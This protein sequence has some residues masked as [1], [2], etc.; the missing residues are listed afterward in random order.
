MKGDLKYTPAE[1]IYAETFVSS[2][3]S[4]LPDPNNFVYDLK[5]RFKNFKA[6]STRVHLFLKH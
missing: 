5:Q 4:E 2:S 6:T 1:M 3:N